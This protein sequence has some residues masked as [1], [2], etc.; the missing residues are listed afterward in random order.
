MRDQTFDYMKGIGIIAMIIG[1]SIIPLVLDRFIFSWHMPLF[2]MISGYFYKKV[3]FKTMLLKNWNGLLRPYF[4]TSL[5][6]V[7]IGYI[8]KEESWDSFSSAVLSIFIASGSKG[9]P[10]VLANYFIGALWF[11]LAMFWCRTLYNLLQNKCRS[12]MVLGGGNSCIFAFNI[13]G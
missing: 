10:T 5:L 11:L 8:K 1:H 4:V 2:F 3:D 12:E 9:N 7:L 13:L 6:L